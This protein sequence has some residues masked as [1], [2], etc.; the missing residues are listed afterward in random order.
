MKA[1]RR[2][3]SSATACSLFRRVNGAV[4]SSAAVAVAIP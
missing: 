2:A 1:S 3:S 4:A